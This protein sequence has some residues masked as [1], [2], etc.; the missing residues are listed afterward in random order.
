MKLPV[1][2]ASENSL[3]TTPLA[4]PAAAPVPG[5]PV[6]EA[7]VVQLV[8][9]LAA[10]QGSLRWS[11]LPAADGMATV[12]PSTVVPAALARVYCSEPLITGMVSAAFKYTTFDGSGVPLRQK[13]SKAALV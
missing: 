1:P 5:V 7:A 2:R 9:R 8:A 13:V 6:L 3:I 4:Q 10:R 11:V 12:W